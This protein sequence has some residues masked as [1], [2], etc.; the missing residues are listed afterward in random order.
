MRSGRTWRSLAI[1][2]VLPAFLL[3]AASCGGGESAD[4]DSGDSGAGEVVLYYSA[5]EY[6][7]RPIIERFEAETG[8]RVRAAGDTEATKTT[9]LVQRLRNEADSPRADVFWSSEVFLTIKLAN[10]G[11]L[12]PHLS[13]T[14]RS[15]PAHLRDA[16]HE[17]HAFAQR[18]RVVVFNTERVAFYERP[19][20]MADLA[21]PRW[22]GRVVMARPQFGTTRGHMG[23]L[24]ALWGEDATR[25][26]MEAMAA[27]GVRLLDG[28]AT[29][30]QAVATGE[31]D[32]G[33]TD[34]DDVWSGQRNGW[35]VDAIYIGH[36][37]SPG[38]EI[39]TLTIPNT[40][41]RV[42]GGPNPDNAA[43]LIDYLLSPDVERM[44]AESDSHNVPVRPEIAEEF[45]KYAIPDPITSL[46]Y[47]EVAASMD[48][49]MRLAE[50]TL[51][52]R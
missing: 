20:E 11:V 34:T 3:C 16:D 5:D 27:R 12:A 7:A 33:L 18:A 45:P 9:G 23:A 52:G 37:L 36:S 49:A 25:G 2:A 42:R 21:E 17:W 6:V 22:Q 38:D 15:W 10:E 4:A 40:V 30:V 43:R 39:G 26:W 32:I 48:T 50:E 44:L 31:A 28:N 47:E 41:A 8:V 1:F 13:E 24:I 51:E 46:T 14:T 29:V 35:P 19:S